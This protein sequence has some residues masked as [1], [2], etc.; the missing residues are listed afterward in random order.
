MKEG[1]KEGRTCLSGVSSRAA[2]SVPFLCLYWRMEQRNSA[3]TPDKT[4]AGE[5]MGLLKQ[6]GSTIYPMVSRSKVARGRALTMEK[7]RA[8]AAAGSSVPRREEGM[9]VLSQ[10]ADPMTQPTSSRLTR[11]GAVP[12][13]FTARGQPRGKSH[14]RGWKPSNTQQLHAF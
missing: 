11:K 14:Q 13:G 10:F 6:E 5:A 7:C 9:A 4:L 1:R 3:F 2:H 12:G 8:D